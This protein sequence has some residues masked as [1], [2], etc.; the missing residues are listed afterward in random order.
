MISKEEQRHLKFLMQ[1]PKF[2]VFEQVSKELI[3]HI[4]EDSSLRETEWETIKETLLREGQIKGIQRFMQEL[5][6][7]I[8]D[9]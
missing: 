5:W 4:Q 8:K 1:D 9:V 7:Q 6:G 2:Q 3:R